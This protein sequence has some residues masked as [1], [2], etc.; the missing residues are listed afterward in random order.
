VDIP[1]DLL[2]RLE[3]VAAS[4]KKPLSAE[5]V[6]RLDC[7]FGQPR[8]SPERS[9]EQLRKLA[10]QIRGE[11]HAVGLTPEFLRMAREYGRE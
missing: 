8:V 7:S 6:E 10:E 11:H 2:R 1:D 5:V 9:P 3:T 4:R